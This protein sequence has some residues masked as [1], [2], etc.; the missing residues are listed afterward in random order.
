MDVEGEGVLVFDSVVLGFAGDVV[1]V[2]DV[3]VDDERFGAGVGLV[4]FFDFAANVFDES[5]A[6][7][8]VSDKGVFELLDEVLEELALLVGGAPG[9]DALDEVHHCLPPF[10]NSSDRNMPPCI[11][12]LLP[13]MSKNI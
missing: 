13:S 11:H 3:E 2:A 1:A 4:E 8:V 12:T 7:D 5:I 9:V 10:Y 6:R